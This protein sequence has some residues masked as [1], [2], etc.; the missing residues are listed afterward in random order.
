MPETIITISLFSNYF[1]SHQLP[2]SLAL[3]QNPM[4]KFRFV[5]LTDEGQVV[6][7]TNLDSEY[8]FVIASYQDKESYARAM[9][10]AIND[11]M[12]V[13]G[14]M[15]GQECFVEAR[16]K[17]GKP[18]MRYA[19]RILK[20]GD[21]WR[22]VPFKQLRTWRRFTKYQNYDMRV[23]CSSAFTCRDLSLFGFPRE[24][25]LKWGYFPD[26]EINRAPRATL[27]G[28][29]SLCSAQRLIAL[30]RVDLQV[31]LASRLKREGCAF[32]LCIAGDGPERE[33]LEELAAELDVADCVKFL[34]ELTHDETIQ[35]MQDSDIFLATSNRKEGWGATVNEAMASGCC[36]IASNEMGSAPYLIETGVNGYMFDSSD[37]NTLENI[38]LECMQNPEGITAIQKAAVDTLAG[39]WCAETA[40]SRLIDYC[41]LMLIHDEARYDNGPMSRA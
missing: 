22:F 17:T 19:E 8:P 37:D 20:R 11:D 12:V 28:Y 5:S 7:R 1:N 3:S 23:L 40:A 21:W 18:F 34:G 33:R 15:A 2:L 9:Q 32:R 31:R 41:R 30:K 25:C 14:D 35:L 10:H 29:K 38:V 13:F 26:V 6:G 27:Q 39:V 24:K 36:V 4:I 16:A